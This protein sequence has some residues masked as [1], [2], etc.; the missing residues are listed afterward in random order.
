[1]HVAPE[2]DVTAVTRPMQWRVSGSSLLNAGLTDS[3]L[4]RCCSSD[5]K[6]LSATMRMVYSLYFTQANANAYAIV[7]AAIDQTQKK[8]DHPIL[9]G[10]LVVHANE[11]G[12]LLTE[13]LENPVRQLV[14]LS[15]HGRAGLNHDL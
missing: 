7:E 11:L 5:N 15:Q 3:K 12:P 14:G 4:A 9:G 2:S 1:M 10:R 8:T 13:E 6:F